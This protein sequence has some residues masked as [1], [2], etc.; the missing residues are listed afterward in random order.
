MSRV[1]VVSQIAAALESMDKAE[2]L[3]ALAVAKAYRDQAS[4]EDKDPVRARRFDR[5]AMLI[6]SEQETREF[7]ILLEADA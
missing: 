5:V 7:A 1:N 4:R 2:L 3:A 6:E